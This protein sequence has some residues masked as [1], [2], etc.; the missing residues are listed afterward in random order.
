[1]SSSSSCLPCLNARQTAAGGR[2]VLNVGGHHFTTTRST[3]TTGRAAGSRLSDIV[4]GPCDQDGSYFLDHDGE[5]FHFVLS[6]LRHGPELF[7]PPETSVALL[8]LQSEAKMLGLTALAELLERKKPPRAHEAQPGAYVNAEDY[9]GAPHPENEAERMAKLQSLKVVDTVNVDTDYDNITRAVAAILQVPICL[10]SLVAED[11]QWFKSKC[12]LSAD[13]TPR[14]C[15]FC[16]YTLLPEAIED[17]RVLLVRDA[18]H[19]LRFMKNPLV[20]GEPYIQ[21]YG[22]C[23]LVTSEGLRLGSL[24]VIDRVPRDLRPQEVG[25]LINFA[26]LVVQA[27]EDQHLEKLQQ[28]LQ[29]KDADQEPTEDEV[30]WYG[31]KLRERAMLDAREAAIVL[32]WARP[33]SMEWTLFFANKAFKELT[34]VE[35]IAPQ[36]FPGRPCV[37]VGGKTTTQES[38]WDHIR[39]VSRESSQVMELWKVVAVAMS[40]KKLDTK[41]GGCSAQATVKHPAQSARLKKGRILLN[42]RFTPAEV[43]ISETAAAVENPGLTSTHQWPK[44]RGWLGD[45]HWFFV[46]MMPEQVEGAVPGEASAAPDSQAPEK[47]AARQVSPLSSG[48]NVTKTPTSPFRDVRLVRLVGQGSFGSVYFSLW[49]GA[50]V[51]VKMIKTVLPTG[52]DIEDIDTNPHYEAVLSVSISHPNL[53]Q[54]F[55]HGGRVKSLSANA[56][57]EAKDIANVFETWIVQEWCDGGTLR[58]RC[59]SPRLH[60]QDLLEALEICIEIARAGQYLHDINIIHGDLTGNNVLLKSMPV[61]KGYVC[62]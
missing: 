56:G 14:T 11:R 24:C 42:C 16:A 26:H 32:V 35:V 53:V 43:P 45:G 15:S 57:D 33:D 27:L 21:F 52:K 38:L 50:A 62:K 61:P 47:L 7:V 40:G 29:D 17:A 28:E 8:T 60:D 39:L 5:Q 55:K 22:G 44:P 30:Q 6:F 49:S 58:G 1:M 36:K 13:E 9:M 4:S 3:L 2:V 18:R 48:N 51:A 34:D 54:T 37:E 19:D 46:Q 31:G 10:V 12:G 41:P 23:P 59:V 20:I 25:L